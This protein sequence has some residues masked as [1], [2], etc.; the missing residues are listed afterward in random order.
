MQTLPMTHLDGNALAG[1][2][3]ELFAFDAT[4]ASA[5]CAGCGT[6]GMLA[7]AMVYRDAM[8]AVVRCP[9]CDDVLAT[10][11]ET[12]DR[13]WLSLRGIAALEVPAP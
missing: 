3:A 13:T 9:G 10:L 7:A 11:V 2:L 12:G 1:P 5:R 8:G 4:T 6:I